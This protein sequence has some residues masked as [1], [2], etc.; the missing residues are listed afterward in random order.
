MMDLDMAKEVIMLILENMKSERER[1]QLMEQY[2]RVRFKETDHRPGNFYWELSVDNENGETLPFTAGVQ[3]VFFW[4]QTQN[5][6]IDC[7]IHFG[8]GYMDGLEV[9]S[10]DGTIFESLCLDN[11]KIVEVATS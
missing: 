1:K 4:E 9:Y 8:N 10:A 6:P 11:I 5:I 3:S 2:D 7:I